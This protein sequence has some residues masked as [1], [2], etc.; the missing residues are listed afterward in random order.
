MCSSADPSILPC[1]HILQTF[2][3]FDTRKEDRSQAEWIVKNSEGTAQEYDLC[4]REA[5]VPCTSNR[6][7]KYAN[8]FSQTTQDIT[9]LADKFRY[10]RLGVSHLSLP[11]L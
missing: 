2:D 4:Q 5:D 1:S 8:L 10:A 3:Q 11:F 9:C 7:R 6:G